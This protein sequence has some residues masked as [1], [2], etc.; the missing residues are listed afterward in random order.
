MKNGKVQLQRRPLVGL[1]E[2][3]NGHCMRPEHRVDSIYVRLRY[4]RRVKAPI[5]PKLDLR[6]Q[7]IEALV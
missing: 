6:H 2:S 3:A 1:S 4:E 7:S 5:D